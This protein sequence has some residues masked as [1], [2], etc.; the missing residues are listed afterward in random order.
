MTL[1]MA[2]VNFFLSLSLL[3][4]RSPAFS[5]TKHGGCFSPSN[6]APLHHLFLPYSYSHLPNSAIPQSSTHSSKSQ[7]SPQSPF[8]PKALT[9]ADLLLPL[10]YN[11]CL[12]AIS[13]L[14]DSCKALF[15]TVNDLAKPLKISY[16]LQYS[17]GLGDESCT[18]L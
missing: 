2:A 9:L 13:F 6:P 11:H 14:W 1:P 15:S 17:C 18:V 5:G 10:F 4:E 16:T 7:F 12:S 3:K 8:L